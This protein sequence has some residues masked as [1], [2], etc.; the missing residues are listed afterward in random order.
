MISFL[1][2]TSSG[3]GRPLAVAK[4]VGRLAESTT[5]FAKIPDHT[6]FHPDPTSSVQRDITNLQ[7]LS[8]ALKHPL[9]TTIRRHGGQICN[10]GRLLR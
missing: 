4:E 9:F 7:S 6:H 1:G 10:Q 2:A 8:F 3:D 5:T